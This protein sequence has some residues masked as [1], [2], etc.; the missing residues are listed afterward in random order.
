[1]G[2]ALIIK[3]ADFSTNKIDEVETPKLFLRCTIESSH[4]WFIFQ[5]TWRATVFISKAGISNPVTFVDKSQEGHHDIVPYYKELVDGYTAIPIPKG[6]TMCHLNM[7]NPNYRYGLVIRTVTDSSIL[8][9]SGW[10]WG[11]NK[12]DY[13][14]S[15]YNDGNHVI[16]STLG[17]MSDGRN[18][19][20]E[21]IK[22]VG[23][24]YSFE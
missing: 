21:T 14:V 11:G 18:F 12:I 24:S 17:C 8:Y 19:T 6:A 20:N 4:K 13:D 23:Y 2:K 3:G 16:T 10:V 5:R 9:D 7:A 15:A 22:S 1:M